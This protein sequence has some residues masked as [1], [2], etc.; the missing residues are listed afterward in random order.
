MIRNT[1]TAWAHL[2]LV[3]AEAEAVAVTRRVEAT[4]L[5]LEVDLLLAAP[6]VPAPEVVTGRVEVVLRVCVA[7][8][9]RAGTVL[10]VEEWAPAQVPVLAQ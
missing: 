3:M 9:R 5:D 4:A 2:P 8:L 7:L 1:R 6:T 10:R